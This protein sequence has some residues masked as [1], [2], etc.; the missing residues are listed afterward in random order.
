MPAHVLESLGVDA[1]KARTDPS[2]NGLRALGLD[3]PQIEA[4]NRAICGTQTVEGAPHLKDVHLAVFDCAN[5]C[6]KTGKRFIA[7]QGHIR[8][9]AAAQPFVSGAISKTINLPAEAAVED[10]ASA[11]R[12]SWELGLK[13]NALYRDGSKLSQPLSTTTDEDKQ[14]D[15][16]KHAAAVEVALGEASTEVAAAASVTSTSSTSSAS[17]TAPDRKGSG[18]VDAATDSPPVKASANGDG[19]GIPEPAREADAAP[20]A[21]TEPVRERVV[22]RIV[23]RPLRRRLPDTRRS[24]T[25]RFDVAGHEGY[26]TVGLYDDGR[27]GELFITMSKE[28][29]TIGGLMDCLGTAISVALQY[30]VPIESLVTKFAHQRFEPM[31][32][33]T[34]RDVPF[35]KSLVDYIF[36]WLGMRFV[37]GYREANAPKRPDDEVPA[38][39]PA[40]ATQDDPRPSTP[41]PPA[42]PGATDGDSSRRPA[43]TA[44]SRNGDWRDVDPAPASG[45]NLAP[46]ATEVAAR[47]P[48]SAVQRERS[49]AL[50]AAAAIVAATSVLNISNAHLMGDA[51]PCDA[52]GAITVRNGNCYKCLNC[53]NSMG[54]S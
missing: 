53:G 34:N 47:A 23:E 7:T 25:H 49:A 52:C 20:D 33:T 15:E 16:E 48:E 6:G 1:K 35:A 41:P 50:T 13:A 30:G 40:R 39:T 37:P 18:L 27:P 51:P 9:M 54:C 24:I 4:L 32:M 46:H 29:S 5:K 22:E 44:R 11:Y 19:P 14:T 12:L 31:G 43:T 3:A 42:E 8:M 10:I 17:P 36:R 45:H 26:L 38:K 21:T 28:G 2:F